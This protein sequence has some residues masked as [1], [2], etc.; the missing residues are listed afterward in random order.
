MGDDRLS[1][2]WLQL[3]CLRESRLWALAGRLQWRRRLQ[4]RA[5][6]GRACQRCGGRTEQSNGVKKAR[7]FV[8]VSL[9]W[10]EKADFGG[11]HHL[12]REKGT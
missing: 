2:G 3:K 4:K 6:G 9:Q 11:H 12:K 8:F 5:G 10:V 1:R 7:M